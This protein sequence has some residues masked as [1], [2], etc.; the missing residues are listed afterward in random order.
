MNLAWIAPPSANLNSVWVVMFGAICSFRGSGTRLPLGVTKPVFSS[1]STVASV[2]W[3][4]LST[5]Q[6]EMLVVP[7]TNVLVPDSLGM[8]FARATTPETG[9]PPPSTT[10]TSRPD[11]IGGVMIDD[12]LT[13]S[14]FAF[15][16]VFQVTVETARKLPAVLADD[17]VTAQ[18][19][20]LPVAV[21]VVT[22][23]LIL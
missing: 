5:T 3:I 7:S 2:D 16:C 4:P 22:V 1:S 10:S 9:L 13:G 21:T 6:P 15:S 20:A 18:P 12:A 11:P 23:C 17:S 14:R 8:N 19:T